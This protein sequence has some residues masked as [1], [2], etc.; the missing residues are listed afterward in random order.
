MNRLGKS[1]V[2]INAALSF[3][4]VAWS[5]GLYTQQMPWENEI[6]DLKEQIKGLIEAR[7]RADARWHTASNRV[8]Q[9]E[10]VMPKRQDYYA[11]QLKIAN[12]GLDSA[13]KKVEP[14][15]SAPVVVNGLVDFKAANRAAYQID[16]KPALSFAGYK[17]AIEKQLDETRD[18]KQKINKVTADTTVLTTEVNGTKLA[19]EAITR[20]EKGLRG[21]LTD[22]I[23]LKKNA[24]LEQEFLQSPLTN[25]KV[26]LELLKRRQLALE[27]RLKELAVTV[28]DR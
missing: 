1:L 10:D 28:I 18:T 17:A 15:V 26:E 8:R 4:F 5:F 14:P 16:G 19:T 7:D 27:A 9:L 25:D 6:K 13:G 3:M 22:A 21:Q 11:N 24:Q 23:T 20:V 12:T 2:L